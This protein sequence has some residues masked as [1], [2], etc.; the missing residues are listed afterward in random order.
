MFKFIYRFFFR[1][2]KISD[3]EIKVKRE[4]RINPE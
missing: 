1:S 2:T 4:K 3:E